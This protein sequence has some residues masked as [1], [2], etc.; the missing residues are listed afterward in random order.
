M[1]TP[2]SLR[3]Q[4]SNNPV[5]YDVAIPNSSVIAVEQRRI[6]HSAD[7]ETPKGLIFV[8]IWGLRF[9][10]GMVLKCFNGKKLFPSGLKTIYSVGFIMMAKNYQ[11]LPRQC[12]GNKFNIALHYFCDAEIVTRIMFSFNFQD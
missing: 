1:I 3:F 7:F 9:Q 4:R 2:I 10:K 11:K 12:L 5:L 8:Q 6:R